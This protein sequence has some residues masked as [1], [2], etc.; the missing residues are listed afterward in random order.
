MPG[1]HGTMGVAWGDAR[2]NANALASTTLSYNSQ[3][4]LHPGYFMPFDVP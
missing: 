1:T 3:P 2:A 4:I